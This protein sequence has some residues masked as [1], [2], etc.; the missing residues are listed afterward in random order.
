SAMG[1][2]EIAGSYV[3]YIGAGMM[4]SGG[5]IGAVKLIPTIINS[6]KATLNGRKNLETGEKADSTGILA[7]IVGVILTFVIAFIISSNVMMALLASLVSLFLSLLFV[8]V[9][10]RLTG[11]IGTSNLPVSGMTI[12]SLVILSLVFLANNW[13]TN[14]NLQT[15]LLFGTFIVISISIAAGYTQSQKVTFVVGGNMNELRRYYILAGSIGVV[16]V[17]GVISLLSNQ[18]AIT[19]DNP[20]FALPQANLMTT[21]TSGIVQGDLPWHMIFVGI[22]I[23][24]VLQ[25]LGMSIMTFAIGFYLPISTSSII[26]IGAL[27]RLFV[28]KMS[29][30]ES[31][32]L[33]AERISSGISLSSGLVAG[34]SI[35]GLIGIILQVTEVI[36]VG[37]PSGFLATNNMGW[38]FFVIL[39]LAF[40]LPIM[41]IKKTASEAKDA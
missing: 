28:D 24:I 11:T 4:I 8:I 20:P 6:V 39:C 33:K 38:I 19:G 15:L 21:L 17:V 40:I 27:L 22:V 9:A 37:T 41:S 14:S 32:E 12:A 3:K 18:L 35:I 26:L 29:I 13:T 1:F 36:K 2:S 30:K 7:F 10:G 16:V 25:M 31:E 34:S 5:I 23:G